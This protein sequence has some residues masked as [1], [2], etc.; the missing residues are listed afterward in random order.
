LIKTDVKNVYIFKKVLK[1]G[2]KVQFFLQKFGAIKNNTNLSPRI[3]AE[4]EE[5]E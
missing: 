5:I 2:Q 4:N 3:F 1:N